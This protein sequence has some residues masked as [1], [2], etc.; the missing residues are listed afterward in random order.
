MSKAAKQSLIILFVLL[1]IVSGYTAFLFIQKGEVEKDKSSLLQQ[2]EE[3]KIAETKIKL[4]NQQLQT[5]IDEITQEKSQLEAKVAEFEEVD[6]EALKD[7]LAKL[8]EEKE[9]WQDRVGKLKKEREKLIAK[10]QA[11]PEKE[12]VYKYVEAPKDDMGAAPGE[13]VPDVEEESY[14]ANVLKNKADLALRLDE[15]EQQYRSSAVELEE[16]KKK[17]SDLQL[18]LGE[19]INEKEII[20]R[21]IKHGNDLADTLSLELART[22]NEK[23]FLEDRVKRINEENLS[24][25][26]KIKQLTST[27]IALEKSVVRLQ[28]EKKDMERKLQETENVI[29]SRIDEIWEIKEELDESFEPAESSGLG[30][31]ELPPI[32]VS[33]DSGSG[34]ST[35]SRG[36]GH[37]GNIVSINDDNN[38]VIVDIGEDSGLRI[39]DNLSVYRG[40]EYVAGLEVI[41]LRENIAAADI[42]DKTSSLQVGDVVR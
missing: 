41:Q 23:K 1:L 25:R 37:Q 22:Q 17:N 33:A 20:E 24:L 8:A 39:G 21:R 2:V 7:Q 6:L 40:A 26:D 30:S 4:A 28:D 3:F 36:Y 5:R 13:A 42:K 29:Q 32:V 34:T 14:W 19:I 35:S 16:F 9:E 31:I 10:V 38:F 27:K 15:V 18:E 12:I 11:K